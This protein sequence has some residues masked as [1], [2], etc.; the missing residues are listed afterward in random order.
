MGSLKT[1]TAVARGR[2][3]VAWHD[4]GIKFIFMYANPLVCLVAVVCVHDCYSQ[5]MHAYTQQELA[6]RG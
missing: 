2:P 6:I 1:A 3:N 5:F 4:L